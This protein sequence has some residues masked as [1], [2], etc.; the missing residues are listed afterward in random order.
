MRPARERLREWLTEIDKAPDHD[1]LRTFLYAGAIAEVLVCA[2]VPDALARSLRK[3][4]GLADALG[5]T[6]EAVVTLDEL[7][8]RI[9]G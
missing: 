4:L 7:V 2:D 3:G 8:R 5:P 1:H 9:T 6:P